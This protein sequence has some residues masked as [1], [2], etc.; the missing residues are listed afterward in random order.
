MHRKYFSSVPNSKGTCA[1]CWP[2]T[3]VGWHH[4]RPF[5]RGLKTFKLLLNFSKLVTSPSLSDV[6]SFFRCGKNVCGA[7]ARRKKSLCIGP[8]PGTLE[9]LRADNSLTEH[10]ICA[11]KST[12]NLNHRHVE[13]RTIL[14][15]TE[16]LNT[17]SR[18][19]SK[20]EAEVWV[21]H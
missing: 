13:Q 3:A 16:R 8:T 14:R 1:T 15:R 21:S 10:G 19:S 7:S 17:E 5:S 6:H 18:S 2:I 11:L 20:T 9:T 4:W 12:R